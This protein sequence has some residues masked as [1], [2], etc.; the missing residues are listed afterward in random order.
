M[1]NR[2]QS[3][4]ITGES[5][6]D[7]PLNAKM[8]IFTSPKTT[9]FI[10]NDRL[11]KSRTLPKST[12][13]ALTIGSEI[14][15]PLLKRDVYS[16]RISG[17]KEHRRDKLFEHLAGIDSKERALEKTHSG[18]QT[19][20]SANLTDKW[21]LRLHAGRYERAP[22]FFELFGDRGAVAGNITLANEKSRK[23]DLTLIYQLRNVDYPRLTMLEISGYYNHVKNLIRFIQNSQFV[24]RLSLIH[25]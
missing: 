22:S 5:T 2:T 12:R 17:Q 1:H 16:F 6:L 4:G 14:K 10:P 8:N 20:I 15:I 25:I 3:F 19:G 11:R 7:L 24:S 13:L 21:K 18:I 9:F 23:Y